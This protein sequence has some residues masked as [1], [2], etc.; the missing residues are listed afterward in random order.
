MTYPFYYYMYKPVD[1]IIVFPFWW[2]I[3]N[4]ECFRKRF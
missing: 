3:I 1:A 4:G 2:K